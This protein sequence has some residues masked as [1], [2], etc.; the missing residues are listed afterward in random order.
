MDECL[1]ECWLAGAISFPG[2]MTCIDCGVIWHVLDPRFETL[3]DDIEAAKRE[4]DN[5]TLF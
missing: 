5:P 1:H 3:Q 2:G 4:A